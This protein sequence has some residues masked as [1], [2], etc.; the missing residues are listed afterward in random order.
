MTEFADKLNAN[1]P[2]ALKER[3]AELEELI[4]WRDRML[5]DWNWE[6]KLYRRQRNQMA[7]IARHFKT[8]LAELE[9]KNAEL[10][11]ERDAARAE[12]EKW[13]KRFR[14]MVKWYCGQLD[15]RFCIILDECARHDGE[16][17][18]DKMALAADKEP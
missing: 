16:P 2:S 7:N 4:E 13:E 10:E 14:F 6:R 15:C 11:A 17:K 5:D 3:I 9:R 1:L 12:K 18:Y 8:L